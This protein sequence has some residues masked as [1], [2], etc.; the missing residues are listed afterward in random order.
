VALG[1]LLLVLVCGF[2]KVED[3]PV[4]D[5]ADCATIVEDDA[6][7]CLDN[8]AGLLGGYDGRG[9]KDVL[10]HFFERL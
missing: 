1:V 2:G 7:G 5:T 9:G 10:F 3:A 6:A 8:S 4:L